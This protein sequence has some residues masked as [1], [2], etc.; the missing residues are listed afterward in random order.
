M[1]EESPNILR[2]LLN[3]IY[4]STVVVALMAM[5]ATYL[6]MKA[7]SRFGKTE[8]QADI[9]YKAIRDK[10]QT[11]D[12]KTIQ[13]TTAS[14][15]D[16]LTKDEYF[17]KLKS[18]LSEI[19]YSQL[20]NI[21]SGPKDNDIESLIRNHHEQALNQASIQFWFSLI[22]S[23][24]GFV[25]IITMILVSAGSVWYEYLLGILPGIV[26]E[27]VSILFFKQSSETR[28][29]ASDFLNRLRSDDQIN[30]SIIIADSINDEA[31]KS[32]IKAQIALH[33]CGISELHGFDKNK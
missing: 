25:F 21:G 5:P 19:S 12:I 27:A 3:P 7:T 6:L 15:P 10:Q 17:A 1:I 23:V 2:T 32:S 14:L 26:I 28:E 29:R 9:L 33:I 31:L 16:G 4:L 30:K 8:K 11:D 20:K 24:V 18:I 22:A 13:N